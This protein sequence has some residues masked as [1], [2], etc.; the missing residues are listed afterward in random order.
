[1]GVCIPY[2]IEVYQLQDIPYIYRV[3]DQPALRFAVLIDTSARINGRGNFTAL[4]I[5][6]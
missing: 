6:N 5:C 1:M 2:E 3:D 4:V